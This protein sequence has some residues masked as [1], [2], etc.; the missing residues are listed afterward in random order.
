M[1]S[2]LS[3]EEYAAQLERVLAQCLQPLRNVPFKAA[4]RAI[5]GHAVLDFEDTN[6]LHREFAAK[7]ATAAEIACREAFR[8]GIFTARP[9]EAGNEI[10]PFVKTALIQGGLPAH[11]PRTS[12]GKAK[13][14]GY[15]DIEITNSIPAYLECKTYN[16]KNV[17]TTMRAFYFS[18]SRQ[19]KV[20]RDALHL[21]LAFELAKQERAGRMAFVPIHWKLLTL[22][23][24]LVDLKHEFNQH[25]RNMYGSGAKRALIAEGSVR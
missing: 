25:N 1:P 21:L 10:E 4:I 6:V 16:I 13:A 17:E 3:P 23:E 19:F 22:H 8:V 14:T 24:L 15:P 20:T 9:N 18:P 12:A 7:I 11:T 2:A 5:C